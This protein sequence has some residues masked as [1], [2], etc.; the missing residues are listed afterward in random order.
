LPAV[1]L[2]SEGKKSSKNVKKERFSQNGEKNRATRKRGVPLFS[3]TALS[4]RPAPSVF[5]LWLH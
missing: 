2:Y 4:L 5:S 3:G 1:S